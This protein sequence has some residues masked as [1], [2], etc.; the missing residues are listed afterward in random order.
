MEKQTTATVDVTKIME[1]IRAEI[2]EKDYHS[3]MLSFADVPLES[4]FET[5]AERFDTDLL[6][7]SVQYMNAN[8]TVQLERPLSGNPI[9]ML[10]NRLVRR[11]V[12]FYVAPYVE[13]QNELN[14]AAAQAQTQIE[15][16]IQESR[17]HSTKAFLERIEV[18][19]LQQKN[20]K[21]MMQQQ[22]AQIVALQEKLSSKEGQS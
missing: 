8:H 17:M 20:A 1:E 19:E 21:L 15:R 16:Y 18:L 9:R 12:R 13:H 6:H 22:Q 7:R 3:E 2:Q 10:W 14:A 5:A 11:M 4:D